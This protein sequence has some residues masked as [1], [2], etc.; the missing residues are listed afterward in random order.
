MLFKLPFV[1][2]IIYVSQA[3]LGNRKYYKYLNIP[4]KLCFLIFHNFGETME[5]FL[6]FSLDFGKLFSGKLLLNG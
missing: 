2:T 3:D 5:N 4:Q 6:Q 1:E